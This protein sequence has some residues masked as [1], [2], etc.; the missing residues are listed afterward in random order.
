MTPEFRL[1]EEEG[2]VRGCARGDRC[3]LNAF[4]AHFGGRVAVR[5]SEAMA[6]LGVRSVSAEDVQ[7]RIARS[8]AKRRLSWLSSDAGDGGDAGDGTESD[9]PS[10]A[11]LL[12]QLEVEDLVLAAACSEGDERA[13]ELFDERYSQFIR[14][15]ARQFARHPSDV[16]EIVE[17]FYAD[18]FLPRG[19]GGN[20]IAGFHG[21]AKL[22]TW[23]RTVLVYRVNDYYNRSGAQEVQMSVLEEGERRSIVQP[24]RPGASQVESSAGDQFHARHFRDRVDRALRRALS[25]LS[26]LEAKLIVQYYV[27]G[28]TVVELGQH[29]GV[30]KASVSRWLKRVR[31]QILH[32]LRDD[33]GTDFPGSEEEL[34]DM[35]EVL[36]L[37]DANRSPGLGS[38]GLGT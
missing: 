25:E 28:R 33:L 18:L 36:G 6:S 9:K 35:F 23:L 37:T 12:E 17:S 7:V 29:N 20:P 5:I 24:T 27:E 15:S 22:K 31:G 11:Q 8:V 1:T 2:I 30:H 21:W 14:V 4:R 16:V 34:G 3:S 32:R 10:V 19:G 38:P 13:W 26:A